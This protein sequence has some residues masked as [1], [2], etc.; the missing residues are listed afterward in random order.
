MAVWLQVKVCGHE[1]S[2]WP[3]R[4]TPALSVTQ[5]HSCSGGM[6]LVAYI[7]VICLSLHGNYKIAS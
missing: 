3:I 7:G 1:F 4:C 6:Q 2:L 5:K